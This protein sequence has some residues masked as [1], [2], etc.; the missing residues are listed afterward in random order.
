M[1]TGFEKVWVKVMNA[2]RFK[3]KALSAFKSIKKNAPVTS[4][5]VCYRQI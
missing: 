2:D 5:G 3:K 1:L 4:R